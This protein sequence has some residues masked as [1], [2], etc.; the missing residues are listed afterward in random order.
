MAPPRSRFSRFSTFARGRIVGKREEGASRESIRKTVLKK[1]GKRATLR[2]IDGVLATAHDNP[3]WQ[4]KDSSAGGRPQE[5]DDKELAK[6]RKLIHDE[7]GLAKV[8]VAYMKKRLPFLRRVSKECVRKTV[9]RLGFAWR[10][11]RGKAAVAKKYKPERLD[12]CDWVLKRPQAELNRYAYVDGTTFYLAAT[13]EQSEDK[14][15]AALGKYCYRMSTGEDSLEDRNVGPSSYAKAQGLPVKIWGFF[16][17][18]R[19]EYYVLPKDV[20]PQGRL[21]T[22]HMNGVRYR[23]MVEKHFATWR[24]KCLPRGGRV[25]IVKDY[26]KFL[27]APDT[28]AAETRAGCDQVAKY[29]KSSPDMNAIEG[30]W[31]KLKLYLEE[32][33][34][35]GRETREAFVRRLRRAVDHLNSHCRAQG[36][37]LC[38]NQKE[39][40]VQCK[41]LKGART[42][43]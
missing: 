13:P 35:S 15:R 29:P 41:K 36:R 42:K 34:P 43:W 33:E 18:G 14:Q 11:R 9:Q 16:C 5:L 10:L 24:K 7:V 1:D 4:G 26:E 19:L 30:W 23:A 8:T 39:R 28:I 38:R 37:G 2:S 3:E 25:F 12:W 27:R 40:A 32:R 6:I 31:R 17:D 20:T 21:T 22:Q